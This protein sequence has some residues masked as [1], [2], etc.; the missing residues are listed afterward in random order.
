M[1]TCTYTTL[2]FILFSRKNN[3]ENC[4]FKLKSLQDVYKLSEKKTS[5]IFD[6]IVTNDNSKQSYSSVT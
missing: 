4:H 1:Y 2:T 3:H 5:H 6:M